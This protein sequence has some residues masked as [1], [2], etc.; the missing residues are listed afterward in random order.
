MKR[1]MKALCRKQSVSDTS[2]QVTLLPDMA[3]FRKSHID[4]KCA[5]RRKSRQNRGQFSSK[6]AFITLKTEFNKGKSKAHFGKNQGLVL[7]KASLGL[8]KSK[9]WF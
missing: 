4:R 3:R 8:I 1:G 2:K 7:V 9:A 5:T 6:T